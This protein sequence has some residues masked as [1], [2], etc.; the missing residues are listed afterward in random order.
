MFKNKI[1]FLKNVVKKDDMHSLFEITEKR[2]VFEDGSG[3]ESLDQQSDDEFV[4]I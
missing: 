4:L 3:C 1:F 2:P